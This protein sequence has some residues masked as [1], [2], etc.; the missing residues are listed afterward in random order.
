MLH[1]LEF[2][3]DLE[4]VYFEYVNQE[5]KIVRVAILNFII[6]ELKKPYLFSFALH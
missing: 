2:G 3:L 4:L 5:K 1:V 6:L